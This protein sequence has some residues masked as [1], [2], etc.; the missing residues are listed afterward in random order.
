MH[1][2]H[3]FLGMSEKRWTILI[4]MALYGSVKQ[5][6]VMDVMNFQNGNYVFWLIVTTIMMVVA[7]RQT[8]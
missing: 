7:M 3:T 1:M 4:M 5:S 6:G 2:N 8:A